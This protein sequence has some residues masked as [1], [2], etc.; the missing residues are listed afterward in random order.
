MK[1]PCYIAAFA[2]LAGT[3]DQSSA[4]AESRPN[5]LIIVADDLGYSDLGC[6]GGEIPTP[7][8][9]ALARDGLRFT[10]LS[11]SARCCP[12]RAS[13]LTGL[14]PAQAGIPNFGGSL[15]EKCVT[16]AEVLGGAGYSTYAVGKWH[17][18]VGK[19]LPTARG[20]D[21]FY[22]YPAGHSQD[23]WTPEKYL[24][25]PKDRTPE[26]TC[27][28]EKFY[29][30]DAFSD[31]A[32]EFIKQGK[33]SKK[34]WLLYLAHS[35]PHFPLQ[36][37]SGSV[38]AFL[39]TYR[40]G[41]DILREERF[42]RMKKIGLANTEG[43]SLSERSRVPLEKND[44]IANGY[45]GKQN[46]AWD[47]L[48]KD[49]QEDLAHRM[50]VYAAMVQ[51]LDAGVGRIVTHLKTT[52]EFENTL[53]L[54]T[55]DNGACYEWGPFGFDD[56]SRAGKTILHR[57]DALETMG[58]PG[59][60]MA[61]GSAWANL[62]NTPF[63]F[64]KHYTHQGGIVSPLIVHWPAGVQS[65]GR[66]VRDP[67]H[68]M[69]IMATLVGV[70]RAPYPAQRNGNPVPP[71]EGI[72]LAPTFS[73]SGHLPARS[74]CIQH[75]GSKAVTKGDWK[76][77]WAEGLANEPA[78]ELYDLTKDPCEIN[79]LASSNPARVKVLSAEW[80][81]WAERTEL[82]IPQA[83]KKRIPNPAQ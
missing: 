11:N 81:K 2:L 32:L 9:D 61:Y 41:W 65:P 22:G 18:G 40:R 70:T 33:G 3:I 19:A 20:F 56:T 25:L 36:A 29:A 69:D 46:P 27:K 1:P 83:R 30:T 67:A 64:Y 43:W 17:V 78:W 31:Y 80:D 15:N 8:I 6:Y 77:V 66:W 82:K 54:V 63:R 45:S 38:K 53:I 26:V 49:R 35:S 44:A 7:N 28:P 75:E 52:G 68:I 48:P 72:S 13:L 71:M 14:H 16:F 55:S 51:H 57:G 10:Q 74:I 73:N 23:Q 76:L 24:R 39:N 79:D 47:S 4:G 5:V 12:S 37:T 42:A 60:Y 58:G 59:T 62:C 50:A 21:E 34:P